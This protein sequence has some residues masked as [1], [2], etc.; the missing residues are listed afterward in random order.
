MR[1][2]SICDM[3]CKRWRQVAWWHQTLVHLFQLSSK[4]INGHSHTHSTSEATNLWTSIVTWMSEKAILRSTKRQTMEL[5]KRHRLFDGSFSFFKPTLRSLIVSSML[6]QFDPPP[7]KAWNSTRTRQR[8]RARHCIVSNSFSFSHNSLAKYEN[9]VS[10]VSHAFVNERLSLEWHR[11]V[12]RHPLQ[13]TTAWKLMNFNVQLYFMID[14]T[15]LSVVKFCQFCHRR[16]S[17]H[18]ADLQRIPKSQ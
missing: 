6:S 3:W 10:R 15:S 2:N 13:T 11:K 7:S 5:L 14:R 12:G 8:S 16:A 4:L 18:L 9:L 1:A 17:P